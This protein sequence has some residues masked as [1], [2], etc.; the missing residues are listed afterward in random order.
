MR[1]TPR[2][3]ASLAAAAAAFRVGLASALAAWPVLLGRVIFYGVCLTVLIAFWDKVASQRLTGAMAARIPAGGFG[4]Y[5]GVTEWITLSVTAVQLK[6][7]DDIRSGALEPSLLRPKLYLVQTLAGEA[8]AMSARLLVLGI[9]G[10]VL[11]AVT[12]RTWPAPA[13]FVY[14]GVL[15]VVGAVLGLLVYALVG[16][17]AFWLRRVLPPFLIVQKLMFV[18]GGLFA[19]ISLYPA[20]LH[21]IAAASPFGAH[22]AFASQQVLTPSTSAFWQGLAGQ[23]F[24]IAVVALACA[25]VWRAGL[26]KLM[27]R[28]VV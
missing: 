19:P 20:W 14:V 23:A 24:W 12:A 7:E 26:A 27:Q 10:L 8:G 2:W 18:L 22:L 11:L 28:G 13:T 4:V 16:L 15:G 25:L 9:A 21:R 17:T 1:S 5:V 6:L 3:T